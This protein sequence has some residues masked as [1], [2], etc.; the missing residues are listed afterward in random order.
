MT[1]QSCTAELGRTSPNKAA[2]NDA[3][4]PETRRVA[5]SSEPQEKAA[6]NDAEKPETRRVAFADDPQEKAAENDTEKPETSRVAF[7]DDP[8]TKAVKQELEVPAKKTREST[9]SSEP[10]QRESQG[11]ILKA[12]EEPSPVSYEATDE[13]LPKKERHPGNK[14]AGWVSPFASQSFQQDQPWHGDSALDP[15]AADPS[16]QTSHQPAAPKASAVGLL[17]C[18]AAAL[19]DF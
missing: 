18:F 9:S 3:E 19:H 12:G 11:E 4:K 16:P 7:S 14:T 13:A 6:E 10:G 17:H 15:K 5:F 8:Q 2:E 1:C